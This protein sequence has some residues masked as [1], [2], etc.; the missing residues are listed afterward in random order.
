MGHTP[1]F[2]RNRL[3]MFEAI[4]YSQVH[5]PDKNDCLEN[6]IILEKDVIEFIDEL[7]DKNP[8]RRLGKFG[9]ANEILN[10]KFFKSINR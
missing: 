6:N 1:F 4:K 7:L 8:N 9:G 5:Y 10:H 2:R 3:L